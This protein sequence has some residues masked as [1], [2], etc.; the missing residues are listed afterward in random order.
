MIA[1]LSDEWLAEMARL[2]AEASSLRDATQQLDSPEDFAVA[3]HITDVP[4]TDVP[5][6]DGSP[7]NTIHNVDYYIKFGLGPASVHPES[8]DENLP[9]VSFTQSYA[10]AVAIATGELSAQSA[11]MAGQLRVGGRVDLLTANV[12]IM[13]NLDDV[14]GELRAKTRW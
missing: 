10:T 13:E 1:F 9:H 4:S 5:S 6:T 12:S 7:A 3:Q 8:V 11:F 2:V 14:L